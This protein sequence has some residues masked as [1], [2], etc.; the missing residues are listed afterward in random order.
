M[1]FLAA[2]TA[3][4]LLVATTAATAQITLF[5]RENFGGN[6]VDIFDYTPDLGSTG[7]NDRAESAIVRNGT[8][9]LC[10]HANFGGRCVTLQRGEYASLSALGMRRNVSSLRP[11]GGGGVASRPPVASPPA[12]RGI[13][14]FDG[15]GFSGGSAGF[16]NMVSNLDQVGFNDRAVSAIVYEGT[17]EV[18]EHADFRGDCVRLGPGQHGDLGKVGGRASSLRPIGYAAQQPAYVPPPAYAPPPAYVPP[19]A[20]PPP[21]YAPAPGAVRVIL[22]SAPGFSGRSM[23]VDRN[24]VRSLDDVGF[25]DQAR[26]IRVERG[27]WMFCSDADF[28]GECRTFGPGD[29]PNLPSGLSGR[30]SS[31]RRISDDYPYNQAPNWR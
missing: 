28:M 12:G 21:A 31:A 1:R 26:S 3:A 22:Y 5:D 2:F 24:H 29:Y 19:P 18:C 25:N 10:E 11:L 27:Y 6:V 17:W 8:W 7:M 4:W 14:L 16:D 20:Y 13:V 23:A 30:I 9:Q 15:Y